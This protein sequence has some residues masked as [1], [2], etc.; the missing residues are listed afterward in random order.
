M[1]L[2]GSGPTPGLSPPPPRAG[3]SFSPPSCFFLFFSV[4]FFDSSFFSIWK[5]KLYHFGRGWMNAVGHGLLTSPPPLQRLFLWWEWWRGS[6]ATWAGSWLLKGGTYEIPASL[7]PCGRP[8]P[9]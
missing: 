7:L 8:T 1:S 5:Q 3:S 4:P 9:G 6:P 2:A